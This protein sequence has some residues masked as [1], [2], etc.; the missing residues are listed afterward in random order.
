[1]IR[2]LLWGTLLVVVAAALALAWSFQP[3]PLKVSAAA[4]VT[5]PA[6]PAPPPLAISVLHAGRMK[7]AAAM[8]FRGG[9][10]D[11][12]RV[13]GMDAVLVEHPKGSLLI[14][15]GFGHD[16]DA[17]FRTTPKLMQRTAQYTAETPVAQQLRD[18]GRDPADLMAVV[19]THAHWDHVSGLADL[20]GVPVWLPQA[21]L[22]FIRSGHPATALARDLVRRHDWHVVAFDDGPYLGFERS[23]D[24]FDD[25]TVVL[26]PAGGHTPGST[27]VFLSLPDGRRYGLIG[28]LVWQ[29]DGLTEL[30]ERPWLARALVDVDA[31]D[32][33]HRI[34]ELHQLEAQMPDLL[35][36]PAHDRERMRQLPPLR[37]RDRVQQGR[38]SG[39]AR[40]SAGDQPTA[41]AG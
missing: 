34:V 5:V 19:L 39:P 12:E 26:V 21:E 38:V 31:A 27:I 1:M 29:A 28:D 3:S 23:H 8:A 25:G 6:S 40:V 9:A 17:H 37:P 15:S 33:R 32:V 18:S 36:V 7:S 24:V 35:L 20:P 2:R 4:P 13:F 14:D 22:D 30:A 10:F 41:S 11:D 16:V